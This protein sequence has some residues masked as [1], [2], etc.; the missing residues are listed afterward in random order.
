MKKIIIQIWSFVKRRFVFGAAGFMVAEGILNF[1]IAASGAIVAFGNGFVL[2]GIGCIA[3]GV[4]QFGVPVYLS[5]R[6]IANAT[7]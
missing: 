5:K 1:T 2:L 7:A 4:V 6:A 3:L